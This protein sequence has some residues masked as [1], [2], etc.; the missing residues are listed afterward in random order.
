MTVGRS[1][2][3]IPHVVPVMAGLYVV[4]A[5]VLG[6]V[7]LASAVTDRPIAYFTREPATAVSESGCDDVAC[8]YVGF[9]SNLGVLVWAAGAVTC[10]LVCYLERARVRPDRS[11]FL[12]AGLLTTALL[13]DDM[14]SLHDSFFPAYVPQ[15][16]VLIYGGFA[17]FAVA[18]ALAFRSFFV[19]TSF[20]LPMIAAALF[21]ASAALDRYFAGHH[22][23]EDGS[24]FL[25]LVTWTVYLV[26]TGLACLGERNRAGAPE[27]V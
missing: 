5:G 17:A 4:A 11:P 13:V 6:A 23:L 10:Y 3:R 14:F 27:A 16:E 19:R 15:A 26:G 25:G 1:Y 8:S 21:V 20:V 12:Y 22:L 7:V 24:K 18:I 2:A 9:L